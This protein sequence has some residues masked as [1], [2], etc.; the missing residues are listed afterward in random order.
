MQIHE[1]AVVTV[2]ALAPFLTAGATAAAKKLGETATEALPSLFD[3]LKAR[4]SSPVGQFALA[5]I[6]KAP[7]KADAQATLRMVLEEELA[8]DAAFHAELASLVEE[9]RSS[10]GG[11]SQSSTTIGVGNVSVQTA[12]I[13]HQVLV[14]KPS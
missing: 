8:K 1:L 6:E 9:I 4:L 10:T 3:K 11:T 13:G 2:A 14:G 12:G 5:A 7:D